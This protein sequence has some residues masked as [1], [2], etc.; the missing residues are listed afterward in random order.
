M[1]L[2][3]YVM[4]SMLI[5]ESFEL[6]QGLDLLCQLLIAIYSSDASRSNT[7]SSPQSPLTVSCSPW[8]PTCPMVTGQCLHRSW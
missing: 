2:V 6:V 4:Y 7:S 5:L 8:N 1:Y 3:Q